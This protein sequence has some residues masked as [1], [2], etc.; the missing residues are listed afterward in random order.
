MLG[1]MFVEIRKRYKL[2]IL[3]GVFTFTLLCSLTGIFSLVREA[4]SSSLLYN[5]SDIDLA[6]YILSSTD[7]N[8]VFLTSA[9]HNNPVYSLAG[10][11]VV[12]GYKGW[13]KSYGLDY[14]E[15]ALHTSVIYAGLDPNGRYLSKYNI[16][17][18][19]IDNYV[20]SNFKVNRKVLFERYSKVYDDGSTQLLEARIPK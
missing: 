15:R 8:S 6:K 4:Q 12:M 10:R 11:Q 19:V 7:K 1:Y 5:R 18:L 17:Y 2:P 9:R 20:M 13:L 14:D 3:C 16:D